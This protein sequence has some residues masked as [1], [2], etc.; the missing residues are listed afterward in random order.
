MKGPEETDC[1]TPRWVRRRSKSCFLRKKTWVIAENKFAVRQM[2]VNDH[3]DLQKLDIHRQQSRAVNHT[4]D[5]LEIKNNY[6][7]LF[8]NCV[9]TPKHTASGEHAGSHQPSSHISQIDPT[10]QC[11]PR[12]LGSPLCLG[13]ISKSLV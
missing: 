5:S 10:D 7:Q 4:V 13:L 12:E 1:L 3:N 11:C 6:P 2:M 9:F 8:Q